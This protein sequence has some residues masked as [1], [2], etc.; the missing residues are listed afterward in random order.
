[1]DGLLKD[2]T[3]VPIGQHESYTLHNS[4][5]KSKNFSSNLVHSSQR[6]LKVSD[7]MILFIRDLFAIRAKPSW[8]RDERLVS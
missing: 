7:K 1:M 2:A 6:T 3:L 5:L 8:V 4:E